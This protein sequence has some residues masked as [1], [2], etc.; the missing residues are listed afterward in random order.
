MLLEAHQLKSLGYVLDNPHN[1]LAMQ[2]ML[3]INFNGSLAMEEVTPQQ[4]LFIPMQHP[5]PILFP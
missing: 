5:A 1:L 3:L 2:Q 4:H